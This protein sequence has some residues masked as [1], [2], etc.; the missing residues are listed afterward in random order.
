MSSGQNPIVLPQA[1]EGKVVVCVTLK[2]SGRM[3]LGHVRAVLLN[4]HCKL[5]YK[6]SLI[7][8]IDDTETGQDYAYFEEWIVKELKLLGVPYDKLV[9]VSDEFS[10]MEDW[11]GSMLGNG[12]A[13]LDKIGVCASLTEVRERVLNRDKIAHI[14]SKMWYLKM[15]EK[16]KNGTRYG[17]KYCV[18]STLKSAKYPLLYYRMAEPHYKTGYKHKYFIFIFILFC[19][20]L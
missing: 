16:V 13:Y 15:W 10:N 20:L 8:R 1:R 11:C 9:Y 14:R 12:K 2:P 18:R 6:G 17:K 7:V 3:D 19:S 5:T 4:E